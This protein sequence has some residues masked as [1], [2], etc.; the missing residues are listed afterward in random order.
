MR[1]GNA[2]FN[3]YSSNGKEFR[4]PLVCRTILLEKG[5]RGVKANES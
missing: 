3:L 5:A 4:F 2:T 1:G